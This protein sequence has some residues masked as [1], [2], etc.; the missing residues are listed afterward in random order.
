MI[1]RGKKE[2]Q[3][4][5]KNGKSGYQSLEQSKLIQNCPITNSLP[6]WAKSS[7]IME[8]RDPSHITKL[9]FGCYYIS[10]NASTA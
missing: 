10:I 2:K 6:G 3:L 1:K 9:L 5:T 4:K 8:Q 7:T